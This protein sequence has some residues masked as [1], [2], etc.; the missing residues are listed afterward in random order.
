MRT[1]RNSAARTAAQKH[2]AFEA[3]VG[4]LAKRIPDAEEREQIM[5]QNIKLLF[6]T[7]EPEQIIAGLMEQLCGY[8][9]TNDFMVLDPQ[10]RADAVFNNHLLIELLLNLQQAKTSMDFEDALRQYGLEFPDGAVE[11][12]D[13]QGAL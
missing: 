13:G 12:W 10:Q 3:V 2:S 1:K 5:Q 11:D 9:Q 8:V 4:V 6:G 7:K